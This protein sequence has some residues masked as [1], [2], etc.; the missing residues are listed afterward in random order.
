MT[1]RPN[2]TPT[3]PRASTTPHRSFTAHRCFIVPP[4]LL[5][6]LASLEDPRLEHTRHAARRALE[7]EHV[8]HTI[9]PG[10]P[11]TMRPPAAH[12]RASPDDDLSRPNRFISDAAGTETL[13]GRLVRSEGEPPHTDAS[14]NE[15]Y[16]GLGYTHALFCDA[17]SRASI[18][19]A[20]LPLEA[21]VHYGE[22]YDNAF[23]DGSRMVFGDG[24]G[25]VF[26]G[27]TRSLSVI[28]HEL[29]HGFIQYTANL[30]YSGQSGALNESVADVF[31]ALVEQHSRDQDVTE[32]SWL[33]GEG[34]F[35]DEVEGTALRSMKAPGTAYD[36]DVLGKDPQPAHMDDFVQTDDDNG[37]VH[38][39]SGI[40]NRAFYLTAAGIGGNAWERAGR[41]WYETVTTE[42]KA[43]ADFRGFAGAT[44]G[45]A[46][47]IYGDGSGEVEAVRS[48]WQVVGVTS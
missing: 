39:N 37:G 40:P 36:D 16:D 11:G 48:A 33:I 7:S 30:V 13:P 1:S 46:G 17:Y 27:F 32:A 6:H 38:I 42:I 26:S 34:I 24:D 18:D 4:Y 8:F 9:R 10:E 22:A 12:P 5:A 29:T 21:T 35:T 45:V 41:I 20:G 15:A 23:W 31:G 44:I 14:V 47:R 25:Q 3:A 2:Q 43:N 28:G 19:G